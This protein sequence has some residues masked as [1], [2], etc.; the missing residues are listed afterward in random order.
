MN[1][2]GLGGGRLFAPI[3]DG[4]G[5]Q[6]FCG[7]APERLWQEAGLT[8]CSPQARCCHLGPSFHGAKRCHP[9]AVEADNILASPMALS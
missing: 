1:R 5:P 7:E 8:H 2:K 9:W 4:L 6:L 3:G